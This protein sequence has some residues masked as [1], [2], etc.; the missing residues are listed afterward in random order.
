MKKDDIPKIEL[1]LGRHL[2]I[3]TKFYVGALSKRLED[4]EIERHYSVLMVIEAGNGECTQQ[5]LCDYL[6]IDK[7]TMV[8]II[9]FLVKK[10]MV[11]RIPSKI[12]R[13]E[14]LIALTPKG[15]KTMGHIHN[16]VHDLNAIAFKGMTEAKQKEFYNTLCAISKNLQ[17]EPSFK[18]IVNYKKIKKPTK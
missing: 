4:I 11:Q 18:V 1:P 9:D 15:K 5:T 3:T 8:R 6:Q 13:R 2:S 12:D 16:G 7:A 17:N 14:H 10:K